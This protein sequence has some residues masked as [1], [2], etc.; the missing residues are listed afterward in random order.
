MQ[1]NKKRTPQKAENWG[2][3]EVKI[4]TLDRA[5][6]IVFWERLRRKKNKAE[7]RRKRS[8]NNKMKVEKRSL[9]KP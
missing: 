6:S 8:R 4:R 5:E 1:N 7:E 9:S 3:I 2:E